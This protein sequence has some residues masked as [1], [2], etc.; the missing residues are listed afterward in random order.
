[1][2]ELT[3]DDTRVGEIILQVKKLFVESDFC[4]G[5]RFVASDDFLFS[6]IHRKGKAVNV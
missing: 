6:K 2:E 5:P 4:Y 1:M 3:I